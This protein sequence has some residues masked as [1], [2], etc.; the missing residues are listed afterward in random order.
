MCSSDLKAVLNPPPAD[1]SLSQGSFLL[2]PA[3]PEIHHHESIL[4]QPLV[5]GLIELARLRYTRSFPLR[6][7]LRPLGFF[8]FLQIPQTW[9]K[10]LLSLYLK[11]LLL[12]LP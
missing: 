8:L 6:V 3:P 12:R 4:D 11:K 10:I 5:V 7:D 9:R 1:A 2:D